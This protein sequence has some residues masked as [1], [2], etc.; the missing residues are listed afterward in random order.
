MSRWGAATSSADHRRTTSST[1]T[2]PAG[3]RSAGIRSWI[4]TVMAW[5]SVT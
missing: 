4:T 3:I 2:L 1:A 5:F